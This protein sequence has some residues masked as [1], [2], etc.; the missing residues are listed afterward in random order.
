MRTLIPLLLVA[1]LGYAGWY[2]W[3]EYTDVPLKEKLLLATSNQIDRIV[4]HEQRGEAP[5]T[6]RKLTETEG[7]VISRE[8]QE[9]LD[10]SAKAATLMQAL[11]QL[12]TDSVMDTKISEESH[13]SLSVFSEEHGQE[14]LQ[15]ALTPSGLG[16][17]SLA[18]G[19]DIF[20]VPSA[21][22]KQIFPLLRFE[23]YRERRLLNVAAERVDSI[24]ALHHDSLLWRAEPEAVSALAQTYIAPAAAPFADYFDE[25][26]HQ[27]RYYATLRLFAAGKAHEVFAYRDSL[28][29]QVYVLVGQDYPRRYLALDSLR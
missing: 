27:D 19:G 10:Q 12:T 2:Y 3:Q 16:L 17:A 21:P 18:K 20:A 24:T 23:Y 29:P 5:F 22:L 11:V 28:W 7:W 4:V 13:Y 6:I 25:I 1:C 14:K 9:L 8:H 15:F 26:A